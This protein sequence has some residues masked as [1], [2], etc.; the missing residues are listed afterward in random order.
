[1]NRRSCS[2]YTICFFREGSIDNA[3]IRSQLSFCTESAPRFCPTT[4]GESP[5]EGV[6]EYNRERAA[7]PSAARNGLGLGATERLRTDPARAPPEAG[8][9]RLARGVPP[10]E[11][12]RLPPRTLMRSRSSSPSAEYM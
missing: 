11:P 1:M 9:T 6:A 5:R 3:L 4:E 8:G 2:L 7:P 10:R 12:A